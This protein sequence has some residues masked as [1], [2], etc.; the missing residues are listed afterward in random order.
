MKNDR[1]V[2]VLE[3]N[4]KTEV[5]QELFRIGRERNW[6][7]LDLR[8][9]GNNVPRGMR[10]V[11]AFVNRVPDD[12]FVKQLLDAKCHV[13]RLGTAP[14][15]NDKLVPAVLPDLKL[16]GGLA[17]EHFAERGFR[18][19]AF[20]AHKPW[21]IYEYL[22]RGFQSEAAKLGCNCHEF[23]WTDVDVHDKALKDSVR[24]RKRLK[25]FKN[26][27]STVP[28]PLGLLAYNDTRACLYN[29]MCLDAG[30]A[31][32]EDIGIL[33]I[34]NDEPVCETVYPSM[35]SI[36]I[37]D[38]T[39]VESAVAIFDRLMSGKTPGETTVMVPPAGLVTR[40]STNVFAAKTPGVARATRF[41]LDHYAEPIS[42]NDISRA[43]GM[44]RARLF[45]AFDNDLSQPPGAILTRIR[46]DKAKQMLRGTREKVL[47]IAEACGFGAS[48]NM[49]HHFKS[50]LGMSPASY[51]KASESRPS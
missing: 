2:V 22:Y 31:V 25:L 21:G 42:I 12:P 41:M 6:I 45:V 33:G 8:F 5:W 18:H 37:D 20:V 29:R 44:S 26:W 24:Y 19:L 46:I 16:A 4:L 40:Q 23:H 10:P 9:S 27:L 38:K 30:F 13:L 1:P 17:A 15:R 7:L 35:S 34:G 50:Q 43:S 48:I 28:K 3:K 36:V 51:R 49:Y 39:I 32:P 11:G 47:T 14:H